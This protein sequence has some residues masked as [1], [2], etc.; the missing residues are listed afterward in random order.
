MRS[1]TPEHAAQRVANLADK[2]SMVTS[3]AAWFHLQYE[4]EDAMARAEE[5]QREASALR[6]QLAILGRNQEME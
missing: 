2:T 6:S 5:L 4:L 3:R 1:L